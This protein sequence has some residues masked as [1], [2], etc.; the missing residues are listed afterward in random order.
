M[1]I[2]MFG[3][4]G[5][6]KGTQ[7]KL[8]Q[9]RKGFFHLSTGDL[10][11]AAIKNGT[12]LGLMAKRFMD[13][14]E[15]VPDDVMIGLVEETM[16][17]THTDNFIL[18]GFPRTAAQAEALDKMFAKNSK[19]I[20][21]VLNL[22]VPQQEIVE[23]LSQR[24]TCLS[25]GATYNLI[26]NP[27]KNDSICDVCGGEVVQRKDDEPETIKHRLN[28]YIEKTSPLIKYYGAEGKLV[29]IDAVGEIETIFSRIMS[30]LEPAYKV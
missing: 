11:R 30:V 21:K 25:C 26:V 24:R 28:V 18:D 4:P 14:G 7:A 17:S 5:V 27:P 10:L 1:L 22:S 6:G 2:L 3:A 8:L 9:E 15:L 20:D 12:E 16:A 29:H 13:R 19:T 23:R